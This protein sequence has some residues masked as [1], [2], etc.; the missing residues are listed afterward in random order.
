[1]RDSFGWDCEKVAFTT[2]GTMMQGIRPSFW[3]A[4]YEMK[5]AKR[6]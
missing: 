2:V 3:D 5:R 1:M 4:S 6:Y